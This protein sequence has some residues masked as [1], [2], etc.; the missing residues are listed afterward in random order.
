MQS[1]ERFSSKADNYERYRPHYPPSIIQFL[2]DKIG[3]NSNWIVA[4]IGSG[5]GISTKLFIENNNT[6]Y[7]VEPNEAMR[8]KAEQS[9]SGNQKFIS[10][11]AT[12]ENTSLEDNSI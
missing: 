1:T 8:K 7:A 2:Q 10:V 12:A 11:D 5:T 4:D 6:V 3:L 9:F